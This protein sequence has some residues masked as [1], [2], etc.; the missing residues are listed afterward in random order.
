[1]FGIESTDK[2]DIINLSDTQKQ[3]RDELVDQKTY[4]ADGKTALKDVA[5]ATSDTMS[6]LIIE[7]ERNGEKI[8]LKKQMM[9]VSD[10]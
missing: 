7:V 1:M 9:R 5:I 10:F 2:K 3:L 4:I 8:T 6:P